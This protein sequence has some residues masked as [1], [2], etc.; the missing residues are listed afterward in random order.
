M[1]T[2]KSW[3]SEFTV[4]PHITHAVEVLRAAIPRRGDLETIPFD[5]LARPDSGVWTQG[6]E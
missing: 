3:L 6:C 4:T 5:A 1:D 2:D